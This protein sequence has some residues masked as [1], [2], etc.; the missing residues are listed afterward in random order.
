MLNALAAMDPVSPRRPYRPS[1][2]FPTRN[3]RA[4][5]GRRAVRVLIADDHLVLLDGLRA[6]LR[7]RGFRVVGAAADGREAVRLAAGTHPDVA[8]LDVIMPGLDG[9][10]A[11]R[12]IARVSPGTAIVL[13]T[14]FVE[15]RGV[16]AAVAAGIRGFVV[17]A[18]ATEDLLQ[19][20]SDVMAGGMYVSPAFS[21]AVALACAAPARKSLLT[22]RE[23]QVLRLIAEGRSTKEVAS[24]L[25]VSAKTAEG[26]RAHIMRK[27]DVHQ[28]AGLVRYAIRQGLISA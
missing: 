28:T 8:V 5:R 18:Q 20:I 13:L 16:A 1:A 27:L 2:A 7:A 23:Q 21:R 15:E 26:H 17:K 11:A 25:G 10:S 9:V 14:G 3:G 4:R 22:A 19:A 6:L 24:V 12:E